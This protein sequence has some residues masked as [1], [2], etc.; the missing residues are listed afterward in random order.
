M[1]AQ[2]ATQIVLSATVNFQISLG[3]LTCLLYFRAISLVH[4]PTMGFVEPLEPELAML[5]RHLP[6]RGYL[7]C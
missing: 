3:T 2:A 4:A 7:S 1:G 5:Q 6:I